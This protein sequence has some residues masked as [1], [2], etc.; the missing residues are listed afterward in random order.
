MTHDDIVELKG[1]ANSRGRINSFLE[2]VREKID[3]RLH[4]VLELKD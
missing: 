2:N 4:L 3:R 1:M